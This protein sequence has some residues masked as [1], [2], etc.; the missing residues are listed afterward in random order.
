[1]IFEKELLMPVK[2]TSRRVTRREFILP[3]DTLIMFD[4][5][6]PGC[7]RHWWLTYTPGGE[8]AF[9]D[10]AHDLLLRLYYDEALIPAVEVTLAQYFCILLELDAYP[11]RSASITVLPKNGF[12]CYL[13]IPFCTL[14]MEL[15][16]RS[17][18]ETC[19]WFMADWQAYPDYND[20]TPMR[21]YVV[22]H[23]E[24]PAESAGSF[25]MAN[26]SGQ[27]FVAGMTKGVRVRDE[28]D[29]WYHTGGD[30]WLLDGET[31]P[32]AM[33]GIGGEDIFGMSFGVW[34]EQAQWIGTPHL[35]AGEGCRPSSH[36]Y[37][38]VNYRFFGPDPIWFNT[39]AVVR[40]GSKANDIETVVYAYVDSQ[41]PPIVRTPDFWQLAG[42]FSCLSGGDFERREWAEEPLDTWQTEWTPGFEQYVTEEGSAV[43]SIPAHA[44]TEHGWCDFARHF[45][46]PQK[47]NHGTQPVAVAAYAVG[48]L[49]VNS[50][51]PYRIHIGFDDWLILWV[52]GVE[53][54][55]GRHDAGF[56]EETVICDLPAG[57]TELR[58]KLSNRDNFQ[59]RLWAFNLRV[60]G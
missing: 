26:F 24:Y 15:V 40:F 51:G 48:T 9:H 11:V 13:P 10:R 49:Y 57:N 55:R 33:R 36:G 47:T 42:P 21:L 4:E 23:S 18:S 16:N 41:P 59:W 58:I 17:A 20:L 34:P 32:N 35:L 2:G 5:E 37:E 54:F 3:G 1:M 14:R 8:D 7:L 60:E 38:C 22:P 45:R 44:E 25:L 52:N 50:A 12:N 19:V 31:A 46:G 39:S 28:S 53:L 29:A 30:L 43:F 6:G 56:S 27:G